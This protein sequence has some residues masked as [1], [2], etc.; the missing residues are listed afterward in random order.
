MNGHTS[1][2][3]LVKALSPSPP[4]LFPLVFGESFP[5]AFFAMGGEKPGVNTFRGLIRGIDALALGIYQC[6]GGLDER[7]RNS[8]SVVG[9][10]I[11]VGARVR[12]AIGLGR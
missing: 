5:F 3:R 12:G 2:Q 6:M 10:Q 7:L 8:R 11:C 9:V 1:R 4:L